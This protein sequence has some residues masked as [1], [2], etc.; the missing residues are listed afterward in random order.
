MSQF[1]REYLAKQPYFTWEGTIRFLGQ[2]VRRPK[3]KCRWGANASM[4]PIYVL[5]GET[6]IGKTAV[7]KEFC[8]RRGFDLCRAI[9]GEGAAT[10][11]AGTVDPLADHG[12]D[13]LYNKARFDRG[14]PLEP[15]KGEM[16]VWL[17][18]DI[19]A[20]KN[21]QQ[22]SLRVWSTEGYSTGISGVRIPENW[23]I[24]GTMNPECDDAYFLV[25]ELEESLRKRIKPVQMRAEAHEVIHYLATQEAMPAL[26]HQFML[27]NVALFDSV[28]PRVWH[29]LA[30]DFLNHEEEPVLQQIFDSAGNL[31]RDEF[32][33]SL[34]MSVD[35][36][37]IY[38]LLR[39]FMLT[40]NDPDE[41]PM[42]A[43]AIANASDGE[44]DEMA[45]R[46]LRWKKKEMSMLMAVTASDIGCLLA[47]ASINLEP[48]QVRRLCKV[49]EHMPMNLVYV[50]V[51]TRIGDRKSDT[52][53]QIADILTNTDV[54]AELHD[55]KFRSVRRRGVESRSGR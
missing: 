46:M 11:L 55:V 44:A 22:K 24:V 25:N 16:G 51:I 6:G 14:I 18:D 40:K 30:L 45:Q 17:L 48:A 36:D 4:H 54:G 29:Q 5:V 42:L 47:D 13:K 9:I 3:A 31:V 38:Q 2:N 8:R 26:L 33:D 37:K 32:L 39:K 52:M 1:T 15:P 41:L 50:H 34:S 28:Q 35:N 27:A 12:D 49:I 23:I 21:D 20:A 43:I 19:G 53:R 7:V 10:D